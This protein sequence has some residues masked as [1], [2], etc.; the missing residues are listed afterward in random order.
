[1][2][3]IGGFENYKIYEDGKII[4]KFGKELKPYKNPDGYYQF[5]LC[6]NGKRK[7]C[8]LNRLLALSFINNP[9][10]LPE[11]DHIDR[12]RSN[13]DL[14]NLQWV[15]KL[16]NC[17]NQGEYSSNTSGNKNIYWNE[18]RKRWEFNK[19]INKKNHHKYSK[20]KQVVIDY[21]AQ[22]YLEHNLKD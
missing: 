4:N 12:N 16:E 22:F 10:N 6:K 1:M 5:I 7:C 14:S 19:Q 21:K 3:S 2:T 20:D 11:V 18:N 17:Q 9:E 15:T 13:N 8:R